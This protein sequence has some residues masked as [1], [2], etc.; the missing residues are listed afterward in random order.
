MAQ[1][2]QQAGDFRGTDKP[3]RTVEPLLLA[4][5]RI[6]VIGRQPSPHLATGGFRAESAAL[7]NNFSLILKGHFRGMVVTLWQ[8]R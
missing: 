4:R 3:F 1:S 6:W 7:E 5:Q 2:P 8:R